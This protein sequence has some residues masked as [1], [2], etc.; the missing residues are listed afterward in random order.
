MVK[1]NAVASKVLVLLI[2]RI[3][4]LSNDSIEYESASNELIRCCFY[5]LVWNEL[6]ISYIITWSGS[7][8]LTFIKSAQHL[9]S[10]S[11]LDIEKY[12]DRAVNYVLLQWIIQQKKKHRMWCAQNVWEWYI[13]LQMSIALNNAVQST[14]CTHTNT[15]LYSQY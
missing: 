7:K 10:W 5:L 6:N 4:N 9:K 15:T 12:R 8:H 13:Q 2:K 14:I 11:T 1:Q 3:T